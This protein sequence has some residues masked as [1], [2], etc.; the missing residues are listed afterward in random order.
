[1]A[2]EHSRV[3]D[4]VRYARHLGLRYSPAIADVLETLVRELPKRHALLVIQLMEQLEAAW[5]PPEAAESE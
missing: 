1:M 4:R 3:S 5:T 2:I